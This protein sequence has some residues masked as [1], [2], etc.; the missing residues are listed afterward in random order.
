[1]TTEY[2][3]VLQGAEGRGSDEQAVPGCKGKEAGFPL[4]RLK[5]LFPEA[6]FPPGE[7]FRHD[8]PGIFVWV[9]SEYEPG[10]YPGTS[11]F[12]FTRDSQEHGEDVKWRQVA[13]AKDQ[14]IEVYTIAGLHDTCKTLHLNDMSERLRMCLSSAQKEPERMNSQLVMSNT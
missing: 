9:M 8:W 13:E 2:D 7:A 4:P 5:E 12:F 10:S 6:L 3:L 14:E 1:L 11:T